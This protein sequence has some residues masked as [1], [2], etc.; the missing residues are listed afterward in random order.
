M[1]NATGPPARS[2][3]SARVTLDHAPVASLNWPR[4]TM[5]FKVKDPA[6]M[7]RLAVG[8][9]IEFEF[10]KQGRHYVVTEIR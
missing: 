6:L 10:V 7:E 8:A 4:M 3:V 9:T 5:G 1:R 2:C